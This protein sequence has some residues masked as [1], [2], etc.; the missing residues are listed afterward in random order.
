MPNESFVTEARENRARLFKAG[1]CKVVVEALQRHIEDVIVALSLCR[2]IGIIA[3]GLNSR[4]ERDE[5]GL[6]YA[7]QTV[8]EVMQRFQNSEGVARF[9]CLAIRALAFDHVSNKEA[10]R[11]CGGCEAVVDA[12]RRHSQTQT[13]PLVHEAAAWA[14]CSL[15]QDD[16]ESKTLL[17]SLGAVE[18]ILDAFEMHGRFLEVTRWSCCALRHL[19]DGSEQNRSKLSF[20]NAA[21]LLSS[22]VQKYSAEEELVE[23]ALL[24][25]IVICADRVG[26]HRLGLVGVCKV[27]L[28]TFQRS[29][30]ITSLACEL[31]SVLSFNSP[32]NQ[33]KLGQAG[34]CKAV[35]QTL[36]SVASRSEHASGL[37]SRK[38]NPFTVLDTMKD[39]AQGLFVGQ[40]STMIE[41]RA[42]STSLT[43]EA[44]TISNILLMED[45]LTA[46]LG[47]A[48]G[49]EANRNKLA[50]LGA[51]DLLSALLA[52][53]GLG[54]SVKL[55]ARECMESLVA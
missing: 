47:L 44:P 18:S 6:V 19:C 17:G 53:Q 5:F 45:C 36:E 21:E 37:V 12:L 43:K 13:G 7:C 30:V 31:I 3:F 4:K 10:I 52:S 28:G 54:D 20:S 40:Q 16:Q 15:A 50:A 8:V 9:G 26:Q 49:H 48:S 24:T 33:S 41:P 25:M 55:K 35:L 23:C 14:I 34:A 22:V 42:V 51:L 38:A 2:T 27:V 11:Q 39:M 1:C 29:D 46:I 32:E